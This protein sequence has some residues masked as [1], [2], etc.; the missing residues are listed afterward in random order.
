MS[1]AAGTFLGR[2]EIRCKIGAGGMGE[3]Y[4]AKDT[5][6]ERTVALKILLNE[7]AY[8]SLNHL[9]SSRPPSLRLALFKIHSYSFLISSE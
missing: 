7:V 4:L 6:L 9:Q 8:T 3:V 1:I 2:Y 5:K